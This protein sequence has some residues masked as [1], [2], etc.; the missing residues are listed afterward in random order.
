MVEIKPE[1][2]VVKNNDGV[3]KDLIIEGARKL[4]T[5]VGKPITIKGVLTKEG[6]K[7]PF[8]FVAYSNGKV[9]GVYRALP[10]KRHGVVTKRWSY[11]PNNLRTFKL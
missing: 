6:K 7:S 1:K 11:T 3:R 4:A 2:N 10:S 9:M 8:S 5:F